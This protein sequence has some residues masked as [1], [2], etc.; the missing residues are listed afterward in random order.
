MS[1]LATNFNCF[2]E[3]FPSLQLTASVFRVNLYSRLGLLLYPQNRVLCSL[4]NTKFDDRLGWNLNL[5]LSLWIKARARLP[6][7]FYEFPKS[8]DDEFAVLF[9]RFVSDVTE[10]IEEYSSCSLSVWVASASAL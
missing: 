8:R 2:S 3:W 9:G 1:V 10:C 5:L 7:L 6:L 4:G